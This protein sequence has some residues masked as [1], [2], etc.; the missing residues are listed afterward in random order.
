MRTQTGW[1]ISPLAQ[2]H[3]GLAA[4]YREAGNLVARCFPAEVGSAAIFRAFIDPFRID[5]RR[6]RAERNCNNKQN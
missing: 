6:A 4:R 3:F 1:D 2:Q 5:R